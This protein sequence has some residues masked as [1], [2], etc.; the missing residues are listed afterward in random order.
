MTSIA[1][2]QASNG[3]NPILDIFTSVDGILSDVAVLQFQVFDITGSPVQVYPPSGRA[4]VDVVG[5]PPTPGAGKLG[6]G[7]F[8][9]LWTPDVTEALGAH[10]ITWYFKATPTATEQVFSESF[11]VVDSASAAATAGGEFNYASVAD[12]RA[13]GVPSSVLDATILQRIGIASRFID[14]ATGR[15]FSPR[16]MT[17]T[18]DGRGGRMLLLDIPIIA[19]SRLTFETSPFQPSN[20]DIETDLMRVYNRHIRTGLLEPDDRDNPKIELYHASFDITHASPY[21]YTRLIFPQGQQ[22]ITV[23]GLFGYTDF[24][25]SATGKTPD[26][27]NHVCK[28]IVIRELQAM[29]KVAARGDAQNRWRLV[30]EKTRDQS[31]NLDPLGK[32][33]GG[34]FT[35]DPEI[36]NVLASYM[37]PPR[38]GGV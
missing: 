16:S 11:D 4:D 9:A 1:R 35:G 33:L 5:Q 37:R 24:D 34:L 32:R 17:L 28:L 10:R 12:M 2:G 25:G 15:F 13:E 21:Q 20:L 30:A 31:Y 27:I 38:L 14:R 19:V 23:T 22:N 8:F 7:H 3:D 18:V 26:L 29:T 6:P 36:D